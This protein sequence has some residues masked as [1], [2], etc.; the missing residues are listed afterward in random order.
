MVIHFIH[1]FIN[2]KEQTLIRTQAHKQS[3]ATVRGN[4]LEAAFRHGRA[5]ADKQVQ[6]GAVYMGPNHTAR[7]FGYAADS[8]DYG[9]FRDGFLARKA[10]ITRGRKVVTDSRGKVIAFAD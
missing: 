9:M 10:E 4:A 6:V 3:E 2:S 1:R 7:A 5:V 8:I